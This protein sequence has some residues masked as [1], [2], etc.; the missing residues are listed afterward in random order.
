MTTRRRRRCASRPRRL[1]AGN[2]ATLFTKYQNSVVTVWS[3]SGH[4]SGFLVDDELGLILTNQH[5][6]GT[7][8]YAA[9]QFDE[10]R[11]VEAKVV[12]F[13]AQRD[14]AVL[15]ANLD[16]FPEAI[17]APL[18]KPAGRGAAVAEGDRVFTIGSPLSQKKILTTG[19][20][21]KIEPRAILS[22]IRINPGNS[23]GPLFTMAGTVV[24]LTAFEELDRERAGN[25]IAGAV[26]IEEAEPLLERARTKLRDMT[27]PEA[28]LLPVEPA[29]TYPVD[30]LKS[31]LEESRKF[32]E[33]PYLF[34][35]GSVRRSHCHSG[36]EVSAGRGPAP[37]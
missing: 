9:V 30:A 27:P 28:R 12:A 18:A 16:A 8:E 3:E 6:I 15:W 35:A 31:S 7:S 20:V 14:V 1:L 10:K 26:R 19:I 17:A 23:G 36:L 2:S 21:G 33:S 5:V 24:G 37:A 13:D 34:R 22:D 32:D 11:K 25:G 4:G 29:G